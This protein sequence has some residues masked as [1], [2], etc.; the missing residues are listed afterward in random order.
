V[1]APDAA[2]SQV[3]RRLLIGLLVLM[4]AVDRAANAGA[5][6]LATHHPLLLAALDPSDKAVLLAVNVSLYALFPLAV[7]RRLLGQCLYFLIGRRLG[8]EAKAWLQDRGAGGVLAK[9]ERVFLRWEYPVVVLAPRDIVCILAGDLGMGWGPFLLLAGLRDC[10]A[11]LLLRE[12]SKAFSKQIESV[13]N[14]LNAYALPATLVAVGLVGVQVVIQRRRRQRTAPE[15]A[16][17]EPAEPESVA[18]G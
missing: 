16:T 15:V 9:L 7:A 4:V 8:P 18:G 17:V 6:W 3:Q 11:V 14:F 5:P 2:E 10:A 12:L 1:A 13:L